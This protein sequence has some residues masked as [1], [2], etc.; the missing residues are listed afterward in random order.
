MIV[1]IPAFEGERWATALPTRPHLMFVAMCLIWGATWIAI[2]AGV[3]AVPPMLFAGTRLIV[4]GAVLLAWRRLSG[5]PLTIARGHWPLLGAVALFTMTATYA[6][7]FWGMRVV[8]SGLSAI[9]HL[10]L[11]PVGL[12]AFGLAHGEERLSA[13][14]VGAVGL[15]LAGLAVLFGP[16]VA[17]QGDPAELWGVAAIV[18]SALLY[19]WGSVLSRPLTRVYAP[20]QIAGWTI[21]VGGVVLL[22]LAAAFEPLDGQV[23]AAFAAPRVLA[24]W[25]F[26]VLFGSLL[27]FTI[28]LRLLRD[29]GPVRAGMY[30]FV[31]P[32]IAV[33]LG[34]A[35]YGERL[36]AHQVA[37]GFLM[38][39]AAWLALRRP[40]V[41]EAPTPLAAASRQ[42]S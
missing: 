1:S 5:A 25:L 11:L 41:V 18:V 14:Q 35:V 24:G 36:A 42:R 23:L 39:C 22:M 29:W 21:L 33:A 10:S 6:L 13:H 15:G 28:Y 20:V 40:A 7:L 37:G 17:A 16:A 8:P 12:Y 26:L 19:G 31:S 34:A 3:E 27:A 4:A 38:L 9:I 30:A 32:A 2:R